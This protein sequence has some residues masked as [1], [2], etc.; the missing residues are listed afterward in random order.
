MQ[1]PRPAGEETPG[2]N[3]ARNSGGG[4]KRRRREGLIGYRKFLKLLFNHVGRCAPPTKP[5]VECCSLYWAYHF[6]TE[7]EEEEVSRSDIAK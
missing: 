4:L 6:T 2:G 5:T 3:D 1:A 7:E